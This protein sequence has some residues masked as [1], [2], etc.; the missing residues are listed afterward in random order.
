LIAD[1]GANLVGV[2]HHR[3]G[4]QVH[5]G[6]VEVALQVETRGAEHIAA[7]TQALAAAG[8]VVERL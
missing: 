8:Y 3:E 5:L 6:E 4:V 2:E 7:V 1:A